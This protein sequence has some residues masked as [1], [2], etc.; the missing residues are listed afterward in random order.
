MLKGSGDCQLLFYLP[1][2]AI[3]ITIST[4]ATT[5]MKITGAKTIGAKTIGAK[6][7]GAKMTTTTYHHHKESRMIS[8]GRI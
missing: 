8:T 2:V 7:I 6:T 3:T 1:S 5:G 4:T